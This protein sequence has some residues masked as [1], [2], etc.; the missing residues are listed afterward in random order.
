MDIASYVDG[1]TPSINA[2]NILQ[3]IF[4]LEKATN[5]LFNWFYWFSYKQ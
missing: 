2:N 3:V 1:N 5:T 4:S